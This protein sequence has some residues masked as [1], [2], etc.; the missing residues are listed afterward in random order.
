M[1]MV[2]ELAGVS[3]KKDENFFIRVLKYFLPWKGDGVGEVF[4][5][6]VFV[7]SIV[8][9]AM[10]VSAVVDYYKIDAKEVERHDEIVQL[11]PDFSNGTSDEEVFEWEVE[12]SGPQNENN[13]SSNGSEGMPSAPAEKDNTTVSKQWNALLK[14]NKD[15]IGWIKISTYIDEN[16]EPYINYPVMLTDE[17][18]ELSGGKTEDFYLHHNFDKK[19]TESGTIYIDDRCYVESEKKR[20]D[21]LT[22]YGHH[23]KRLGNMFTR[24][25]E[26]KSGVEFLKQN[27]IIS[28]DTLYTKNQKYII[29][30]CYISNIEEEQDNGVLFD[31]WRYRDFDEEHTFESFISEINKRSWYK[32]DIECTADD[33]YITLST[34]SNEAGQ[35]NLR[36]VITARKLKAT[37]NID[38]LVDSYRDNE[39]I[40]FPRNWI[41]SKGNK[42][43]YSG[44]WY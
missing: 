18:Y 23:M 8:F 39:N 30:G 43:A 5:K 37:D 35:S 4:R 13:T 31:Y 1:S 3:R 10:S 19:W 12:M 38:A 34:C 7:G 40:Y 14:E 29:V 17:V 25:A 9:F 15:T 26:Y 28:F 24:L 2:N 33:D 44:W 32:S 20:S 41:N 36:W 27:P 6:I 11:A 16:G 21:N 42:P 22:V